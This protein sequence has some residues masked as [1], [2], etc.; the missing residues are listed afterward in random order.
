MDVEERDSCVYPPA[1]WQ[2]RETPCCAVGEE[3][4]ETSV[5][6]NVSYTISNCPFFYYVLLLWER[7]LLFKNVRSMFNVSVQFF[8]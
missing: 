8:M 1:Q 5:A 7:G 4:V 3:S 6:Q 2:W